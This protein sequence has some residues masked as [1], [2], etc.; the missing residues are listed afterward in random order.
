MIQTSSAGLGCGESR[1]DVVRISAV[2][3]FQ[4]TAF[5]GKCQEEKKK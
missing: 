5:P 4:G 3:Y 1:R 2:R